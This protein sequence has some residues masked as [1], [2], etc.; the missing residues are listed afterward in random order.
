MLTESKLTIYA[1]FLK[2]KH[3]NSS[4]GT[5]WKNEFQRTAV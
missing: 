3:I 2:Q 5:V 1:F 4:T